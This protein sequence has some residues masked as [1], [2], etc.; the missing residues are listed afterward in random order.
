MRDRTTGNRIGLLG[1]I[2]LLGVPLG[3]HTASAARSH[4]G[5]S[6]ASA[7]STASRSSAVSTG[8]AHEHGRASGF[9]ERSLIFGARGAFAL[10][11]SRGRHG[12]VRQAV[13]WS[14]K[15]RGAV[16]YASFSEEGSGWSG[17]GISCVPYARQVSGIALTGNAATWWNE[18]AGQYARGNAPEP[19]SVL[20]FRSTASMRLGHVAVVANVVSRREI[21]VDHANWSGPGVGRGGVSHNV[22][23]VDVSPDNDW[24][25]VRVGL[26]HTGEYGSIYPTYGFIYARPD[27]GRIIRTAAVAAPAPE[28]NPA[29]RDLRPAA[30]RARGHAPIARGYDEVAEAPSGRGRGI[31]LSIGGFGLNAPYRDLQ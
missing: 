15:G 11:S 5:A 10:S 16:R 8:G 29:P 6:H 30:E 24:T 25:A 2:L 14:R 28:L 27:T 12:G 1:A 3:S 9:T 31:D 23:V 18:A 4:A 20:N 19:G 22:S 17:G 26:G 13:F 7:R 21:E